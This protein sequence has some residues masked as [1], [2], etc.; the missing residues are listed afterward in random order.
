MKAKREKERRQAHVQVHNAI[1]HW[2]KF[3][4]SSPKYRTVGMMKRVKGWEN[5]GPVKELCEKAEK[6]RVTRGPPPGKSAPG[7]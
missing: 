6:A 5:R 4:S 2:V 3:F 1:E 7:V